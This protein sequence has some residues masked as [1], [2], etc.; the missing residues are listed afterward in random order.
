MAWP[1]PK[2]DLTL[3]TNITVLNAFRDGDGYGNVDPDYWTLNVRVPT[4]PD[5][6]S[7]R[8]RYRSSAKECP[9]EEGKNYKVQGVFYFNPGQ[10]WTTAYIYVDQYEVV[11]QLGDMAPKFQ[12]VALVEEV[13]ADGKVLTRR[14]VFDEYEGASYRQAATVSPPSGVQSNVGK[15]YV[16]TGHLRGPI[17]SQL[18][19]EGMQVLS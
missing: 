8:A 7:C 4:W 18:D 15:V 14:G 9:L 5:S 10:Q 11:D 2:T 19:V 6:Q 12:M 17:P 1:L 3:A 16:F 13:L